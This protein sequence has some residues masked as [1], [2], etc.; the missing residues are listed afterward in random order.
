MKKDILKINLRKWQQAVEHLAKEFLL[1]EAWGDY[2]KQIIGGH[3]LEGLEEIQTLIKF[4]EE[5]YRFYC[6]HCD[7]AFC[8]HL[9]SLLSFYLQDE[10]SF[11]QTECSESL[12]KKIIKSKLHKFNSTKRKRNLSAL[13]KKIA[14]MQEG[15][16]LAKGLLNHL[17]VTLSKVDSQ[18]ELFSLREQ[19]DRLAEYHLSGLVEQFRRLISADTKLVLYKISSLNLAISEIETT[20]AVQY[21]NEELQYSC[22]EAYA[23][24]GHIWKIN[25][26]KELY[27]GK[28]ARLIQ[29]AFECR[30]NN[31]A[32]RLEDISIWLNLENGELCHSQ[33]LRPYK[34]LRHI[35]ADDSSD[36][37]L[38]CHEYFKYPGTNNFR[39]R[40]QSCSK[41]AEKKADYAK[42][43]EL[44]R[45]DWQN[46]VKETKQLLRNP[47]RLNDPLF[48]LNF[49]C[50]STDRNDFYLSQG[51]E[52]IRLKFPGENG[53]MVLNT[54]NKKSTVDAAVLVKGLFDAVKGEIYFTPLCIIN[55][56]EKIRLI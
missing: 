35:K 16:K 25:E 5:G 41:M 8:T 40:W 9:V 30:E 52:S 46:V 38:D 27:S 45:S 15:L 44:S 31:Y 3:F 19:V 32:E 33:N 24:M 22:S 2:S 34:A 56:N 17:F 43:L 11:F 50:F 48:L 29:L 55:S 6:S 53:W 51:S 12:H 18:E 26:L 4:S 49:D 7:G 28:S 21:E 39:I 1:E 36:F 13:K 14:T 20:L 54:L 42:A 23:Y 37:L 10:D 47:L